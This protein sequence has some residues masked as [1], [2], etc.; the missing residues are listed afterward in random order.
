MLWCRL[1]IRDLLW[2]LKHCT[3]AEYPLTHIAGIQEARVTVLAAPSISQR[4]I[5]SITGVCFGDIMK[6]VN[7]SNRSS[8]VISRNL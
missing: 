7:L 8:I 6:D 1:C 3:L 2:G 5:A 4:V